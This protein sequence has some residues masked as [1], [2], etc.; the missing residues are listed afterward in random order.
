VWAR[1]KGADNRDPPVRGIAGARERER[2]AAGKWG[3][4]VSE[5]ERER[6]WCVSARAGGPVG[7]RESG[8]G[9]RGG[10]GMCRNRP[11]RGKGFSLFPFFLSNS[12]FSFIQIYLF[13]YS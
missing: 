11:S 2:S 4:A 10:E 7:P 13:N 1:K 8:T 6:A 9:K 5:R 3:R 12:F